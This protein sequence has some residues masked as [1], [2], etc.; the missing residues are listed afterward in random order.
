MHEPKRVCVSKK[1][2]ITFVV[3]AAAVVGNIASAWLQGSSLHTESCFG[4]FFSSIDQYNVFSR[5][6][7]C[8]VLGYGMIEC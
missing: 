7:K 2:R 6:V 3:A 4:T 1:A 5:I 8:A